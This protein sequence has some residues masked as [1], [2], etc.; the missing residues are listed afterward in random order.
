MRLYGCC[1]DD[2]RASPLA[3]TLGKLVLI[4]LLVLL[5]VGWLLFPDRLHTDF[6]TDA[7]RAAHV[8]EQL[9]RLPEEG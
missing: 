8:L 9:A 7:E 4:K 6:A 2:F 3:R 5:A 1:R